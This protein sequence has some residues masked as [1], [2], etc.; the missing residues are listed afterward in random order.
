M[1]LLIWAVLLAVS[2]VCS[3]KFFHGYLQIPTANEA[4][5]LSARGMP[6]AWPLRWESQIPRK[7]LDFSV[8]GSVAIEN[9]N[10]VSVPCV[11]V[12]LQ[13]CELAANEQDAAKL[14]ELVDEID[15]ML[16]EKQDRLR[17]ESAK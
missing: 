8:H 14:S 16:E 9:V 13:L 15:R 11:G 6:V 2:Q 10:D 17:R 7:R 1:K 4:F 12:Q 5:T 3:N